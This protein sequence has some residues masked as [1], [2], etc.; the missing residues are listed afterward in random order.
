MQNI[1]KKQKRKRITPE[2][3]S[4][5]IRSDQG[6]AMMCNGIALYTGDK[7]KNPAKLIVPPAKK[8][9]EEEE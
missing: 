6:L 1:T 7:I 5:A 4:I 8:K 2:D 9:G 3:V